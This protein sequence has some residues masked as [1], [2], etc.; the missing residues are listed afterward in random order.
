MLD[1]F[2]G[3][4]GFTLGFENAGFDVVAGVDKNE[5]ALE[6]HAQNFDGLAIEEDLSAISPAEFFD[7]Y[8]IDPETIDVVIGGPPCQGFSHAQTDRRVDDERN[9]LVFVF[10]DYVCYIEPDAFVM[11]NVPGFE[12][13]DDGS[14]LERLLADFEDGGYDVEYTTLNAA[15]FGVPQKRQRVFVQGYRADLE[16]PAGD[17][18]WPEPT[19]APRDELEQT[20]LESAST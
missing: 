12:Q 5:T 1:L 17:E 3:A 14:I 10:A 6:T 8:D 2:C 11:E 7:T 13:M 20:T 4:G 16:T 9:N 19:H 15:N 18:W